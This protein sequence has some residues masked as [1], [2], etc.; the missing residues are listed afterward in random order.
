LIINN[1][2][3]CV[4][5]KVELKWSNTRAINLIYTNLFLRKPKKKKKRRELLRSN[6]KFMLP[7]GQTA[8]GKAYEKAKTNVDQSEVA[9]YSCVIRQWRGKIWAPTVRPKPGDLSFP[10]RPTQRRRCS[11]TS[12]PSSSYRACCARANY[13]IDFSFSSKMPLVFF[14]C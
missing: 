3:S 11:K 14:G 7:W 8:N 12:S 5:K 1:N 2:P 9:T 13:S 10:K 6:Q 4:P